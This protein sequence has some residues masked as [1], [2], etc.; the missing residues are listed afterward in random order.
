LIGQ[1]FQANYSMTHGKKDTYPT[2]GS[3][4]TKMQAEGAIEGTYQMYAVSHPY[5]TSFR[6]SQFK[7]NPQAISRK[8]LTA[9]VFD[10]VDEELVK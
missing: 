2:L 3:Y 5:E 9:D 7:N 4:K 1:S 6:F 10:T 8:L